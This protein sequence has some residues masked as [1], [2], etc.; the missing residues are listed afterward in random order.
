MTSSSSQWED[1]VI[2]R[3]RVI[4][5]TSSKSVQQIFDEF[6]EDGNGFVTQVEFRNAIRRLGLGITSREIDQVLQKIDTNGDGRIDYQEFAAKFRDNSYD[7]RMAARAA[8]RMAKLKELMNLH[9]TSANDAFRYVSKLF[10]FWVFK[11]KPDGFQV[12]VSLAIVLIY[13]NLWV[14]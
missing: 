9:M 10:Q 7:A 14:L 1:N 12:A 6:D 8:D 11:F 2:E 3:L 4:I 5:A 13:L